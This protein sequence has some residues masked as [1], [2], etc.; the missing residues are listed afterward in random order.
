MPAYEYSSTPDG[1]PVFRKYS[2]AG[3]DA[4]FAAEAE[5]LAALAA[6]ATVRTPEVM[7]VS[8]S[9]LVTRRIEPGQATADGWRQL[10]QQL[11]ALHDI[12]QPCFGFIGDNY[13]GDTSQPNPHSDDGYRFFAQ[14]RLGHQGRLAL[15]GGLLEHAELTQLEKLAERLPDL[16]P[17]QGPALL[18]GDLWNG[19]V[20]FDSSGQAVVIDPACYWGWP[21]ADIAMCALFGGFPEPFYQAWEESWG[22]AHG[23]RERLPLYQ[24]Y[25]LLN[26]L[27]LFGGGY[28]Q[29]VCAVLDRFA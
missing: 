16:V 14:H 29:Q 19:N 2:A 15:D 24:L 12:E 27:N 4:R 7:S 21:E 18:H 6:T 25:H 11:G 1:L 17:A 26:H 9:E 8:D 28:R 20:L 5:G 13:C 22:P 10:G 3:P 23:W